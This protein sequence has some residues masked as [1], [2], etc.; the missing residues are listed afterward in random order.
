MTRTDIIQHLIDK[1]DLRSYLEIG[2]FNGDN[3]NKIRCLLKESVDPEFPA[4]YRM[5]SDQFFEQNKRDYDIVFIDGLHTSEQAYKD[6]QN[7]VKIATNFIVVHDCNP[8]T[9]W[10]A[11]PAEQYKRGEVWN[12]TTYLG[13]IKFHKTH[14]YL[15]LITVDADHGCG[16]F[17]LRSVDPRMTWDHFDANRERLLNLTSVENFLN[18]Y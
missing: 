15:N 18:L 3:F 16:I 13:V 14:P 7:A 10:A 6:I 5:T 11:R 4:T 1:F 8:L 17:T 9:E 12:G 2:V